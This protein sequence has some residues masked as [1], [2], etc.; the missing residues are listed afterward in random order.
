[1]IVVMSQPSTVHL[2]E[3]HTDPEPAPHTRYFAHVYLSPAKAK[4]GVEH[5]ARRGGH[6]ELRWEDRGG[7][8]YAFPAAGDDTREL[9]RVVPLRVHGDDQPEP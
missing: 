7:L 3:I 5:W 4:A 9:Y 1:M 8:L 6:G 2:V